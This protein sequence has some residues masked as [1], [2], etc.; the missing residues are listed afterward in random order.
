MEYPIRHACDILIPL[1]AVLL[2][3]VVLVIHCKGHQKGKDMIVKGNKAG[4]PCRNIQLA[5]SSGRGLSFPQ[6]DHNIYQR[7]VNKPQ[8]KGTS[9]ITKAGGCPLKES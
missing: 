7:K 4:Q 1:G 5:L 8:T 9:W 2:P 6:R 3:K